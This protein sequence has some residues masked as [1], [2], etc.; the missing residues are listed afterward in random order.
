LC[1]QISLVRIPKQQSPHRCMHCSDCMSYCLGPMQIV[2]EMIEL[3][4]VD[5]AR[6]MLRQTQVRHGHERGRGGSPT[7]M[8]C[9]RMK[10][11]D[12]CTDSCIVP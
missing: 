6:A 7:D 2:L 3:R 11:Y 4:E 1:E 12:P 5:T 8:V 9:L 10:Q